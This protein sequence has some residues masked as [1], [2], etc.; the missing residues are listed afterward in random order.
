V[1]SVARALNLLEALNRRAWSSVDE[2]YKD[3]GLPKPTIVRM[4]RTLI[5]GGY[6]A[7]DPRQNGY[8]VT[9]RVQSLS[10]GFHGDPLVVEAARPWAIALT[11]ELKWPTGIA[12][13]DG[14]GVTIRFS[15]IPDSPISPFHASLNM[16]LSLFASGLGLAY[17]AFCPE[18][19][20][21]MLL[22]MVADKERA[23][24][25]SREPGW[26]DWRVQEARERGYA[27][28]DPRAEPRNSSTIAVPIMV[29]DR[30]TATIGLTFFRKAVGAEDAARYVAALRRTAR[31]VEEQILRLGEVADQAPPEAIA[32]TSTIRSAAG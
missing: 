25:E 11:R 9:P 16:Q 22:A 2:L 14:E 24:L 30:V 8:R 31:A 5:N 1:Q 20:R 26:L 18:V 15:T 6:A 27:T 17:Y 28:R 10:C 3:T 32:A 13:L 23:L 12:I 4:L 29:G 21:E 7:K 19:E